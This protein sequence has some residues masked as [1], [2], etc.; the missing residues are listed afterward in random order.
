VSYVVPWIAST[1]FLSGMLVG[2]GTTLAY[3]RTL[4]ED[5]HGDS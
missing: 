4:G 2:I 5:D 1:F 3:I